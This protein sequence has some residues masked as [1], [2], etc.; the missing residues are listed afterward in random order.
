MWVVNFGEFDVVVKVGK[1][2]DP[3]FT[4]AM[5]VLLPFASAF[6]RRG[7]DVEPIL[8]RNR[9]PPDAL[10]DPTMLVEANAC[11]GA[12]ED[13]A[14]EVGDRCFG[15]SIAIDVANSGSPAIRDAAA[16][17][18]I[19]GDFLSRLVV[20]IARKM[21]NV[22][23]RV[24]VSSEAASFEI[25]RTV[26]PRGATTQVDA[27][28]VAFYVTVFKRGLGDVFDPARI[29][30]IAPTIDGVPEGFLPKQSLMKSRINGLRISFPPEWLWSPFSLDWRIDNAERG[31]LGGEDSDALLVHFRSMIEDS[32][33]EPDLSL[34]R[35]ADLVGLHPRR[36]QRILSA[37]GTSF[38]QLKEDVR[39]GR[40]LELLST[41][42]A[43]MSEIA[44]Q[45]GFCDVTAFDRAFKKWTGR[46][47]G[48]FRPSPPFE[49]DS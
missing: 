12:M 9:I 20:E 27:V 41:T 38:R 33:D 15:A 8:R 17:A 36:V 43:P 24:D 49:R 4:R 1:D 19:F 16:H 37:N 47:P 46:T 22:R 6:A 44:S 31:D 2:A 18:R 30:V 23:Y 10:S 26:A 42:I 45:V 32:I 14:N 39:R 3:K 35:F 5:Y 25:R 34:H 29:A 13:M 11:Y 48:H 7:G 21:N 28:G 40:A